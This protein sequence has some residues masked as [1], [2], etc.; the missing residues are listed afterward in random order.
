ESQI[1]VDD[2]SEVVPTLA[3]IQRSSLPVELSWRPVKA[4][5]LT[6]QAQAMSGDRATANETLRVA[7]QQAMALSKDTQRGYVDS[8]C[9]LAL[10]ALG[11]AQLAI[12]DEEACNRTAELMRTTSGKAWYAWGMWHKIALKRAQAADLKG[13][14]E[15]V[16]KI[17]EE[18]DRSRNS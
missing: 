3:D 6:A 16:S 8:P 2:Y 12:G 15:I 14:L 7:T 1:E 17:K 13:A 10:E 11:K 5:A 4:A 9:C 18:Y